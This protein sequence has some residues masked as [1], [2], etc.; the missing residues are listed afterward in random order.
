M[1]RV[2]MGSLMKKL[3]EQAERLGR[4]I[5]SRN[6][7]E[8]ALDLNSDKLEKANLEVLR[9]RLLASEMRGFIM[10]HHSKEDPEGGET[11]YRQPYQTDEGNE[12]QIPALKYPFMDAR[13]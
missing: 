12:V 8:I 13:I 2:T 4:L 7:F 9:L 11:L 6:D 5:Q 10:A 3:D 1:S